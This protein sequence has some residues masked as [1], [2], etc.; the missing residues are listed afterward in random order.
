[1]IYTIVIAVILELLIL[2]SRFKFIFFIDGGDDLG[3]QL[4]SPD[5]MLMEIDQGAQRKPEHGES[6]DKL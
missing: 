2:V 4:S 6:P 5:M 3:D 1:L